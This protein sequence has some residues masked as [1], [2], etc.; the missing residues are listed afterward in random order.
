[1]TFLTRFWVVVASITAFTIGYNW[2]S[3]YSTIERARDA[4][5]RAFHDTCTASKEWCDRNGP[6]FIFSV[7]MLT[8]IEMFLWFF[9]WMAL[10]NGFLSYCKSVLE[11]ILPV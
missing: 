8:S 9:Y 6:R 1:M 2:S 11:Y 4:E 10:A 5:I 3:V 7:G